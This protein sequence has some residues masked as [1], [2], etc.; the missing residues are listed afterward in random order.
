MP[1]KRNNKTYIAFWGDDGLY[2]WLDSRRRRKGTSISKE[3]QAILM[4]LWQA[5][6]AKRKKAA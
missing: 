3:V 5:E 1:V 4:P 6:Q 2:R